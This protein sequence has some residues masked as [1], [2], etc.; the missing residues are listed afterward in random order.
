MLPWILPSTYRRTSSH[1]RST[2]FRRVG[3]PPLSHR[4][5]LGKS[6]MVSHHVP[7]HLSYLHPPAPA[8]PSPTTA[9]P[10]SDPRPTPNTPTRTSVLHAVS[11]SLPVSPTPVLPVPRAL[12]GSHLQ[13]PPLPLAL[14]P[15][16]AGLQ[17]S[18]FLQAPCARSSVFSAIG[19]STPKRRN[20]SYSF[21]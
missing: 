15:P 12:A 21:L 11:T 2:G 6:R 8:S 20:Q 3:R 14:A 17:D 13:T 18:S 19:R 5:R 10:S 9:A 7:E 1:S 16:P 4:L